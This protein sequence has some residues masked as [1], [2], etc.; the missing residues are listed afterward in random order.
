MPHGAVNNCFLD[1][2]HGITS[3]DCWSLTQD[4]VLFSALQNKVCDGV[5]GVLLK[6]SKFSPAEPKWK[7][8]FL[9]TAFRAEL[10][11]KHIFPC[12]W[13]FG[14]KILG[15]DLGFEIWVFFCQGRSHATS[16][17]LSPTQL[18]ILI[19]DTNSLRWQ[20]P[21]CGMV[22]RISQLC[23]LWYTRLMKAAGVLPSAS[24]FSLLRVAPWQGQFL[25]QKESD[26]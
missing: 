2:K 22:C 7:D 1:R 18:L 13:G 9:R 4:L 10:Q 6:F 15:V 5:N 17:V 21:I 14:V 3:G 24:F 23:W 12:I 25:L 16:P 19:Q 26:A 20:R 11:R 8:T